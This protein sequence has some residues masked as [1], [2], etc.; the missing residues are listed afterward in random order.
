MRIE[1]MVEFRYHYKLAGVIT[2][3]L[4]ETKHE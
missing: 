2:Q 4:Y 3:E 1:F